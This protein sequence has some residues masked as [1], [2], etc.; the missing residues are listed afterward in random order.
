MATLFDSYEQQYAVLTADIT[1]Q[2]GRFNIA[3]T[4]EKRHYI[5][6]IE[7]HVDEAKELLEQMELEV[8]EVD[9]TQRQ[10]YRTRLD[11]YRSELKRLCQ[12]FANSRSS[13]FNTGYDSLD[14]Y[15]DVRLT[16]DQK[17]RLLDNSERI[18]R[19]GNNLSNSYRVLL[20][21]EQVGSQVL[22]D[23]SSQRETIQRSRQRL[24][25]TDEELGRS[26]RVMNSMIIRSI[27]QR[28]VVYA[29]AVVFV[30]AITLGLY[31]SFTR[32]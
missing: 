13:T 4:D 19:T 29:V 15:A 9:S 2:I 14:E 25:D 17:R 18:E 10:R 28:F 22:Q 24:R 16:E 30:G 6:D 8:R 23:L 27:Q 3:T 12:E 5:N 31:L 1:A 21:T 11:C 20:E 32:K 7:K 26:S